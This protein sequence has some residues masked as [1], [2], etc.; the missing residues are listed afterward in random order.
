MPRENGG[1]QTFLPYPDFLESARV[2][3]RRRLGKQRV[4]ALQVFR[5]LTVTGHGWRHH[6]A[7]AMWTGYREALACYGLTICE[8]W[9]SIGRADTCA[10]SISADL[11][12]A[13][14]S[15]VARTRRELAEA[16][17][18]P[19]WLG[20]ADFHRSHQSA[21]LRKDAAYYGGLFSGIPDD[22]SYV[23][24]ISDRHPRSGR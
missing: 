20:D 19:P 21:L 24:P 4:E 18:L 23:W 3:D 17:E 12:S 6:P 14:G 7:V 11:R 13:T 2:L 16:G 9:T 10:A 1:V 22:L 5:A 8:V 15:S